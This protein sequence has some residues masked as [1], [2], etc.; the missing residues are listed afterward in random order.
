MKNHPLLIVLLLL[1]LGSA[2]LEAADIRSFAEEFAKLSETERGEV[3]EVANELRCPTCTGLS[4]LESDAPFSLQMRTAVLEKVRE[5]RSKEEIL[6]FFV[7]RYGLWILRE[8]P[9]EG[10]HL[11]AWLLPCGLLIS[12]PGVLVYLR[13]RERRRQRRMAAAGGKSGRNE[14]LGRR[15]LMDTMHQA[16]AERRRLRAQQQTEERS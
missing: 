11:L 15:E 8:P 4:V 16:L 7:E 12:G 10:F 14:L 9:R 3:R 2:S 6:S 1:L 13:F 5:K